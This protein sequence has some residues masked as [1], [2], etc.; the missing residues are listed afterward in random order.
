[1]A[2]RTALFGTTG[3]D[4]AARKSE[5]EGRVMVTVPATG[6]DAPDI[7]GILAERMAA[8]AALMHADKTPS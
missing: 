1:M 5:R 4:H 6:R 7:P 8:D 2:V 3:Q